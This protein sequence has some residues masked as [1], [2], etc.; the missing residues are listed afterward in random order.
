MRASSARGGSVRTRAAASSM[1]SG[2][3]SSSFTSAPTATWSSSLAWKSRLADAARRRNSC[4]ASS[5]CSG[6]SASASSPTM[7][8]TSR[9]VTRKRASP[10]RASQVPS[11]SSAW[12]AICSKLSRI[13]RQRP[14][15]AMAWPSCVRGSSGPSGTDRPCAT[16]L[17]MPST[18]RAGARSQNHTPPGKSPSHCQPKRVARRVLPQPPMPS[19][20]TS[21]APSSK[22]LANSSKVLW[23][24][25]KASRS[26]G[27]LCLSSRAGSHRSPW[28]TTR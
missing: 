17:K 24:P 8:S 4:L 14:R 21:R 13:T 11:V 23:R 19:T 16:A 5:A 6:A 26:A 1:A 18:V 20:D 3:P 12:R 2:R 25:T 9:E 10:A 15:L 22:R 28:R 27:R 7:P